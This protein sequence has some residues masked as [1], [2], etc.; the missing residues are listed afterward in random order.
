[1]THLLWQQQIEEGIS[2]IN[3]N[4]TPNDLYDPIR[5][6]LGLVGKRLRPLLVF[7][8]CDLFNGNTQEIVN[9]AAGIEVFHNFTL[10]HDD[11]MDNAPVRRGMP[12][13]HTKW[14]SNVAILAGDTMFVKAFELMMMV[15]EK[16]MKAILDLFCK[17]ATEVCEGQQLDMDF[18]KQNHVTIEEYIQMITLKTSVLLACS[19][20]TGAL[21]AGANA[22]DT[23]HI[24]EFGKNVGIAFQIQ[25]DLLDA[26]GNTEKF[27][28]QVGGDIIS[29]KKTIL[30]LEAL[31]LANA[32]QRKQLQ[33]IYDG[34]IKLNDAEKVETVKTIFNVLGIQRHVKVLMDKY[35]NNAV[36][37][38]DLTTASTQKKESLIA[39]C[40]QL[41]QR[42][43]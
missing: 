21:V 11:I 19:L 15:P 22:D 33:E 24:Y 20:K 31:Q 3:F 29:N 14:N 16:Y 8:G 25:D 42:E 39:F 40:N 5:Y 7:C 32:E 13:V 28:K 30:Y 36:S 23:E 12:T 17:T 43:N 18:E 37:H 9:A 2:K 38:L 1:M 35:Y 10:L 4:K 26:Y 41:M 6:S 27:G 34:V